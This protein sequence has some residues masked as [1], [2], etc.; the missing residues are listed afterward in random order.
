[1]SH[2]TKIQAAVGGR[3]DSVLLRADGPCTMGVCSALREYIDQFK[4]P[5]K[6]H[7][8][9]D[10]SNAESIDSTFTGYLLSLATKRSNP[11]APDLHLVSPTQRV[12]E[13]LRVMHLTAFFDICESMPSPPDGGWTDVA[14]H[15]GE[16]N[17]LAD[18]VLDSHERLIEADAR[19][20]SEFGRVVDGLR[21][22]RAKRDPG[23]TRPN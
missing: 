14:L 17:A 21:G 2:S 3:G 20:K 8:Y 23:S 19:N 22:E 16:I 9:I 13:A 4:K 5:D 11:Q 7:I 1:M 12:T 10:L 6:A 15:R 18:I